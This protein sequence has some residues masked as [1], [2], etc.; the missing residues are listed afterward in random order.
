MFAGEEYG[1]W[2]DDNGDQVFA[3]PPRRFRRVD[4]APTEAPVS[5]AKAFDGEPFALIGDDRCI[6]LTGTLERCLTALAHA[7]ALDHNDAFVAEWDPARSE[8]RRITG[9]GQPIDDPSIEYAAFGD[10]PEP[11]AI[12]DR[13]HCRQVLAARAAADVEPDADPDVGARDLYLARRR[14]STPWQRLISRPI[15]VSPDEQIPIDP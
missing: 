4:Y 10:S 3:E 13:D 11:L 14:D 7:D 15:I 5:V 8:Y 6:I 12:G 9:A 2:I 1:N